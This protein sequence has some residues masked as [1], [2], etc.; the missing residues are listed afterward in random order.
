MPFRAK[1][2][3][4]DVETRTDAERN[5]S[6]IDGIKTAA[7]NVD[8]GTPETLEYFLNNTT[9]HGA[10]YLFARSTLRS[11][12]W[13]LALLASLGFCHYQ[14]YESLREYF[15]R[16]FNTKITSKSAEEGGLIFPTV[17]LCN[18][19]SV[20]MNK[21]RSLLSNAD[22][23]R[24]ELQ[25]RVDE[26]SKLL[27]K[28]NDAIT[29]EFKE[30]YSLLFNRDQMEA[31]LKTYGH[32]IEEMLLPNVPPTF[33]SCSYAGL[34]CGAQNFS[35]FISTHF[36]QCF[37][38]NTEQNGNFPLKA[39]MPGKN[40]GLKLRLNIQRNSYIKN[41]KNPFTG[42]EVLVHDKDNYPF[43][44]EYGISVQP[45]IHTFCSIKMKKV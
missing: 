22:L 44:Y 10:R 17:T 26:I 40:H 15:Q 30:R 18:F 36:G 27:I 39:T 38:F 19:N 28:S 13:S 11:L 3:D 1:V 41:T 14:A 4:C 24:E 21:M 34:L 37:T 20:N 7:L 33:I 9:L 29:D 5:A 32:Q 31:F 42:I 45:G 12:L 2:F 8:D 16:P 43:M 35:S 6:E 23:S 25:K